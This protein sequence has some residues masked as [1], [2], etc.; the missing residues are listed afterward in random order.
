MPCRP[1]WSLLLVLAL[2]L[3]GCVTTDPDDDWVE[4]GEQ[5]ESKAQARVT[6]QTALRNLDSQV[7]EFVRLQSQ[8]GEEARQ[9]RTLLGSALEAQVAQHVDALLATAADPAA[10]VQRMI[11]VKSLA[12]SDDARAAPVLVSVLGEPDPRLPTNALFALARVRDPRTEA[13]PIVALLDHADADVRNHA[14]LA[15]RHVLDAR[16]DAG[17]AV[18]SAP[19]RAAA[20]PAIEA[21]LFDPADP[22]IRGHAAATF[23]ALG[24]ASSV[25][26]LL[27][28]LRDE[29]PF[30]RMHT[31]LALGKLGDLKAVPALV[32]IIDES[33]RG[34]PK[35][36]V[37]IAVAMLLEG[38]GHDPPDTLGESERAWTAYVKSV[39]GPASAGE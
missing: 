18:L 10:G 27:N 35:G 37:V 32:S 28:L 29:H 8:P 5:T 31:A 20:L 11:A 36:A 26:T 9:R 25:D 34:A 39:L 17:L 13:A 23:G 22:L 15:L 30:V 14:L 6:Y 33:P 7:H 4:V 21:A 38:A 24:D 16:R 2:P 19:D 12:F 1:V 3:A